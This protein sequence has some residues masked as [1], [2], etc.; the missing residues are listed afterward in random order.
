M[1]SVDAVVTR[2][3]IIGDI[4]EI[5]DVPAT[6]ITD[7]TNVLDIG[8]DSVRLMSLIERWRA[9]GAVRADLVSLAADPVVGSWVRE[10]SMEQAR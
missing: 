9:A 7:D 5:L 10:L 8:L 3:R 1:A 6:E 2:D 4:A